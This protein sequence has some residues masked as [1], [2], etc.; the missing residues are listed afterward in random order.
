MLTGTQFL[1]K[2]QVIFREGNRS[3]FAFVIE[4]GQFAVSRKRRDGRVEVLD[5]LGKND[6]F[7]EMGLIDGN[8]RS[9]T[10]TA[11]KN[12]KVK[13]LSRDDLDILMSKNPKALMPILKTMVERLRR[14]NKE[15]A[16]PASRL[17]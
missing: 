14:S 9:A 8:P 11:L 3:D 12:S 5:V 6:I 15:Q 4:D 1:R 16:R 2:G 17:A 10:V 7:G 13:I